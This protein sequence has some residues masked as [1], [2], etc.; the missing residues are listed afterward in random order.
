MTDEHL[1]Q[2]EFH[3]LEQIE[4][5]SRRTASLVE[6]QEKRLASFDLDKLKQNASKLIKDI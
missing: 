6:R 3:T 5:L 4:K 2:Y 1:S